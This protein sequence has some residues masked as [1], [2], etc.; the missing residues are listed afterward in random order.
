MKTALFNRPSGAGNIFAVAGNVTTGSIFFVDSGHA[1]ASDAAANGHTPDAPFATVDFAINQ[2]TA[3]KG[4]VIYVMPG[5]VE[6][7][8][9][10]VELF[11]SDTASTSIIGLGD[12]D[13][14]PTFTIS[15][16]DASCQI[17]AAGC[18][19]SNVRFI[20][21]LADVVVGL[22]IEAAADGSELDHCYFSGTAAKEFLVTISVAADADR[23]LIHDN[24]IIQLTGD[25]ATAAISFAGGSDG[26][27]VRDNI[28]E[29]DFKTDAAIDFSTAASVG[30]VI[31]N[32]FIINVE[33]TTSLSIKCHAGSTGIIANNFV[34]GSQNNV[35]TINTVTLMHLSENF[36][37]DAANT[38]GILTPATSFL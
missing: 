5:H 9:T 24:V 2:T 10:D 1:E 27:I 31:F 25:E 13:L 32:N 16:V 26:T 38:T 19:V 30:I 21:G 28:I 36:G 17:G 35:R 22:V 12:G 3:E 6:T 33:G 8:S 37:N 29:G 20:S 15:H 34:A 11:D 23:L 4:D 18:R 14:R 7:A